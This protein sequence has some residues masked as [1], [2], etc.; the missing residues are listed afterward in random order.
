[1]TGSAGRK[2]A[3]AAVV[4]AA[5]G[6]G[7]TQAL[8]APGGVDTSAAVCGSLDCERLCARIGAIYGTCAPNG[9]TCTC[10]WVG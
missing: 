6:F 4:A 5:L 9:V 10:Y 3:F 2:A 1:M 7:A 8:A